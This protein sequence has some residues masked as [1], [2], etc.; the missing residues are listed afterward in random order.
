MSLL[1]I[2]AGNTLKKLIDMS[3]KIRTIVIILIVMLFACSC[4][5]Y[6]LH[7]P[8]RNSPP[9][10]KQLKFNRDGGVITC[11]FISNEELRSKIN[12]TVTI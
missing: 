5:P 6:G 4:Y 3:N 11:N 8:V 10:H 7:G 12:S 9:K 2:A 1:N